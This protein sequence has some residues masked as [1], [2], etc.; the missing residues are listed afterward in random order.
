MPPTPEASA[1]STNT[2]RIETATGFLLTPRPSF[3]HSP[4]SLLFTPPNLGT[5]GQKRPRP[6]TTSAA[7][8][9][10]KAEIIAITTPVAQTIPSERFPARSAKV[11]VSNARVTVEPEAIIAGP[12]PRTALAMAS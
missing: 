2:P 12:A 11:R 3:A 7:G 8:S 1:P 6:K 4:L 9:T 5:N 10:T